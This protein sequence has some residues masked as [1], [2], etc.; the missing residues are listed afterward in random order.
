M[1][2]SVKKTAKVP[3]KAAPLRSSGMTKSAKKSAKVPVKAA[4]GKKKNVQGKNTKQQRRKAKKVVDANTHAN[5]DGVEH[6]TS[7]SMLE[8]IDDGNRKRGFDDEATSMTSAAGAAPPSP[9]PPPYPFSKGTGPM[10]QAMPESSSQNPQGNDSHACGTNEVS[11]K[12][13]D[14]PNRSHHQQQQNYPRK[15]QRHNTDIRPFNAVE[16]FYCIV[17]DEMGP[18]NPID[19]SAPGQAPVSTTTSLAAMKDLPFPSSFADGKA[20]FDAMKEVAM[21]ETRAVIG[22][23]LE[24]VPDAR[25]IELDFTTASMDCQCQERGL[26]LVEMGS[27]GGYG[28]AARA[29]VVDDMNRPGNVF[30]IYPSKVTTMMKATTRTRGSGGASSDHPPQAQGP[31]RSLAVVAQGARASLIHRTNKEAGMA[32]VPGQ[33]SSSSSSK[34]PLWMSK[35]SPIAQMLLNQAKT[36]GSA[37]ASSSWN[38]HQQQQ[39]KFTFTVVYLCSVLQ[40]QRMVAACV[41]Y[42]NPPFLSSLLGLGPAGMIV[43]HPLDTLS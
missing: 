13:S 19:K 17:L 41:L 2:K 37:S 12:V 43:T 26:V 28:S 30:L 25:G 22:N 27:I 14:V 3:V 16:N 35:Q 39:N 31:L 7:I 33:G 6:Q 9:P 11:R 29:A 15:K 23:S 20:Y 42:P 4:P 40:Y 8:I 5:G 21:D 38:Q 36:N 32:K 24:D 10:I 18:P 1:K 34:L